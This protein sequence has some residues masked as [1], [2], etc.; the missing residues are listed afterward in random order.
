MEHC[1]LSNLGCAVKLGTVGAMHHA[2][3]GASVRLATGL[4]AAIS[5]LGALPGP[6]A[7]DWAGRGHGFSAFNLSALNFCRSACVK[8]PV[9]ITSI[10]TGSPQVA[11]QALP[12]NFLPLKSAAQASPVIV[13]PTCFSGSGPISAFSFK[14]VTFI[15]SVQSRRASLPP[16]AL[17]RE[18]QAHNQ[19]AGTTPA[20]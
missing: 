5:V 4:T 19:R 13:W 20:R 18:R 1:A 10:L 2:G 8:I 7:R 9:L 6:L 15:L 12:A 17:D 3:A 16:P 11:H 14:S